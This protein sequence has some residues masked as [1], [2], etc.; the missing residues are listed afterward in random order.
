[1][2]GGAARIPSRRPI[3]ATPAEIRGR[4]SSS[5]TV[6]VQKLGGT[7]ISRTWVVVLGHGVT[8]EETR[9]LEVSYD[10]V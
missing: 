8:C 4:N 5:Y 9:G 10:N 1:M 6:C 7:A 2:Q 3:S